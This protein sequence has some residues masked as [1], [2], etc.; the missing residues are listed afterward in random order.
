MDGSE[1]KC[2]FLSPTKA[3]LPRSMDDPTRSAGGQGPGDGHFP[4]VSEPPAQLRQPMYVPKRLLLGPG[5]TNASPR[6]LQAGS[7]QLLGHLHP[8]FCQIMDDVRAGIKYALQTDSRWAL[9]VSGTGH[10]AMEAALGNLLESGERVLIA[11]HGIWGQRASDIADRLGADVHVIKKDAGKYFSLSD[12]EKGLLENQP[13]L[14][15]ITHGESSTGVL[16]SLDGIGELCHR[17]GCL[18]LVDSVAALGG[19]PL[20][21]DAQ[22]IDA[23]YTGSQKVLSC[24]PGPSP[25]AFSDRAWDKIIKRKS[26]I[27][28]FY[29]DMTCLANYW[30][31]DGEARRYHHTG[32]ITSVYMLREGLAGL[33]EERL[34]KCWSR[35]AAS[36]KRLH[37]GLKQLGLELFVQDEVA[38]LPTVTTVCVPPNYAW[39]EVTDYLITKYNIEISGGLGPTAG[40]V[41]R[42][43]LMG[44]NSTAETVDKVLNALQDALTKCR[45]SKL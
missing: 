3:I 25:I 32:P 4:F 40:K 6:V 35:H 18:L 31:C 8:E 38:R 33:A 30:G 41:W 34:E 23:L 37:V 21:M 20:Y 1:H 5:P 10:A 42:I 45:H 11:S 13:V 44:Y 39:K 16:Q 14:F 22:E 12:I 43:G 7:L 36:A 9:A 28:S 17:H 26:R 15:F 27:P 19:V 2:F 24:P 29:F